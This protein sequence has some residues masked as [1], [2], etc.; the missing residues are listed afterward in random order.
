MTGC[1]DHTHTCY[2]DGKNTPEE[3]IQEALRRG[4]PELGFSGHSY[5]PFD[6][7]YCM[8]QQGTKAYQEEVRALQKKYRG[9][10]RIFLGVEQDYYSNQLT[11][12]YSY[13]IGSVHYVKKEDHY[14]P[15]DERREMQI[16]A[17]NRWYGGDFYAFAE[18]YYRTVADLYRRTR[19]NVIG[20]FDLMTKF[21]ED[22]ALFDTQHPRYRA[23]V[24]K[25]LDVLLQEP[26]VFELNT[27]AMARS[28]RTIPYPDEEIIRR[29][30][31]SGKELLLSSD[32]HDASQLL[33]GFE[34]YG[35]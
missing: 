3:L 16:A 13:V 30:R 31:R 11:D 29:I 35:A 2:C 33:F 25:A 34:Q 28:Y 10:I 4:C 1:N 14:L 20:H 24:H 5:T 12:A 15:V 6:E 32:C 26:V 23:E 27:G 17:V 22:N 18:D 9:S 7:S 8:S 19:C 21:N